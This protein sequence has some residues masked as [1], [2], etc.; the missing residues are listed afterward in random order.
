MFAERG[1]EAGK[2][3]KFKVAETERSRDFAKCRRCVLPKAREFEWRRAQQGLSPEKP[4]EK[5]G[6]TFPKRMTAPRR[7]PTLSV[8]TDSESELWRRRSKIR[9]RGRWR[10]RACASAFG[11]TRQRT[12]GCST[13]GGAT[14][15]KSRKESE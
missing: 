4:S 7:N 5:A 9:A 11:S 12:R 3:R 2:P 8:L 10:E 6:H 15:I 13:E 1:N 14:M